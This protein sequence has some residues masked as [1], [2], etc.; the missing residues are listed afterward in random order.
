MIGWLHIKLWV[1]CLFLAAT[2]LATTIAVWAFHFWQYQISTVALAVTGLP[3]L[4]VAAGIVLRTRDIGAPR[5]IA[6]TKRVES[7]DDIRLLATGSPP[8]DKKMNPPTVS[9]LPA[10]ILFALALILSP[11]IVRLAAGWGANAPCDPAVVGPGDAVTVYFPGWIR[12]V[13]GCWRATPH[14]LLTLDGVTFPELDAS[15]RRVKSEDWDLTMSADSSHLWSLS[16]LWAQMTLPNSAD[17]AGK[18]AHC[19]I[20]LTLEY[21]QMTGDHT[22]AFYTGVHEN[23]RFDFDLSISRRG[24]G[25]A[26]QWIWWIGTVAGFLML[27]L[28]G[29]GGIDRAKKLMS[30]ANRT[31]LTLAPSAVPEAT[32][33]KRK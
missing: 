9:A 18:T 2:G 30:T 3:A 12:S 20:S 7:S 14:A 25:S 4:A 31:G 29:L 5:T 13:A 28:G 6:T 10:R 33:G 22:D 17:L 11:E 27:C 15:S 16:Q 1:L 26:Y 32:L 8:A 24:S 21:P 19:T 23:R